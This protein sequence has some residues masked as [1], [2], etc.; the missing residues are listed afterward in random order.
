MTWAPEDK[1]DL[2]GGCADLAARGACERSAPYMEAHCAASCA[3]RRLQEG[4]GGQEARGGTEIT[5]GA[6]MT[7]AD[8]DAFHTQ[9][10]CTQ[11]NALKLNLELFA[12][13]P[14]AALGDAFERKLM[15]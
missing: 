12:R 10:S 15:M 3:A 7:A 11:Y 4:Q 2:I 5:Q 1:E 13:A 9:E 6:A 14:D 8:S